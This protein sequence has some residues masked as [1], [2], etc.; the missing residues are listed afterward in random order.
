MQQEKKRDERTY[1]FAKE[2]GVEQ[3]VGFGGEL[4]VALVYGGPAGGGGGAGL[5]GDELEVLHGV[6]GC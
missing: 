4:V 6:G 2:G 5:G 1:A 3:P